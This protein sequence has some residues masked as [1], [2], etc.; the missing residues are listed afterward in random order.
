MKKPYLIGLT[1]ASGSGKTTFLHNLQEEFGA[2]ELCIISQDNYY[3]PKEQQETDKQGVQNFDLPTSID[4]E[5]FF[6]DIKKLL[7]QETVTRKEY[8]FNNA[9]KEAKKLVF[10]PR[11]IIILEG[12]FVFYYTEIAK[13]LDLKVFLYAKETTALSRRIRRDQQER[14]Y[15]LDDVLYR[16]ENHV[17]PTYERYIKPFMDQAD[18]II[19]N[20]QHFKNGLSVLKGFLHQKLSK[21]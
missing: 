21:K 15:P 14:N 18:I 12:I 10:E 17:Q 19:N 7:R 16:Y 2:E 5:Q 13:L 8:T 20:T 9:D 3:H 1:G 4:R 11:P 6:I